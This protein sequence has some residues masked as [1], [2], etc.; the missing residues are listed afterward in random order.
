MPD[1]LIDELDENYTVFPNE[2]DKKRYFDLIPLYWF[3][4][5][6]PQQFAI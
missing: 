6:L 5:L 1:I 3:S 4:Y 2:D